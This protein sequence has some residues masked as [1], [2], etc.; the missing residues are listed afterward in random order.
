[1]TERSLCER[2]PVRLLRVHRSRSRIAL[3]ATA[4]KAAP[5]GQRCRRA[6]SRRARRRWR[7][8]GPIPRGGG[9]AT[10]GRR[11][12]GCSTAR[13]RPRRTGERAP[14]AALAAASARVELW[15]VSRSPVDARAA[16][17]GIAQGR[18]RLSR[19][20]GVQALAAALRLAGRANESKESSGGRAPARGARYPQD[21]KAIAPA[22]REKA[23][24]RGARHGAG[25]EGAAATASASGAED[26][27]RPATTRRRSRRGGREGGGA[28]RRG[29]EGAGQARS[30][31]ARA[32]EEEEEERPGAGGARRTRL[33]ARPHRPRGEDRG[34]GA[35]RARGC[36]R[37]GGEGARDALDR[38]GR[39]H[40]ARRP[41]R[42]QGAPRGGRCRTWRQGHR[43]HRAARRAREGSGAGH[44]EEARRPP[45]GSSGS[46]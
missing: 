7:S 18:R 20:G 1:M 2:A 35:H 26:P 33:R 11:C 14:E 3:P 17:G 41:A 23:A 28:N 5:A 27:S 21:A 36:A 30:D 34:R 32:D 44:R 13:S 8:F 9:I 46:R 42:A 16:L 45:Q 31:D 24:A 37:A 38:A 29:R 22:R 6:S 4:A 39:R 40:L 15:E 25:A 10:A 12:C 19:A 43:R